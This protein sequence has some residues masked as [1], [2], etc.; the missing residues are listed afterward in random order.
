[1][2]K[3][4]SY[5]KSGVNVSKANQF[6]RSIRLDVAKTTS[7]AVIQ[8]E[9]LFASLYALDKKNILVSS[10]DGVGTKLCI[11][12][13]VNKHSTVGIDLVAM[14]VNDI[15]CVGAKPLFF[16]DYIA[17][18]KL[19]SRVLKSVV[20]GVAKGCFYSGMSLI[21]GETAEM[22]GL[23]K[24]NEYDLA[25]FAVGIVEKKKIIDGANIKAGDVVFGLPSSGIHSNGYS[26]VRRVFSQSEQR[27][28]SHEL[29]KPTRI[30]VPEIEFL[31]KQCKIKGLA[32][33]TGGA[34]VDKL[35]KILPQ[36]KCFQ[37]FKGSWPIPKIFQNIQKR[38][39]ITEHEM[40]STFNMG[41]GMA[42]VIAQRDAQRF[43]QACKT[44][45]IKC[46]KIGNVINH[47]TKRLVL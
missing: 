11:A 22:P 43:V 32:H 14:N 34:Y 16:L 37:I 9:G 46:Y 26:L 10:T 29:L 41:I 28:M 35:T 21:G 25:G 42:L 4:L 13:L 45:R 19:Q 15:I 23:Y 27:R 18:G 30:Y 24:P 44:K 5:K 6:I 36:G 12:Q 8:R 31:I 1:M 20:R 39:K 3:R 2:S 38:G 7:S 47:K 33:I 17:C 40:F